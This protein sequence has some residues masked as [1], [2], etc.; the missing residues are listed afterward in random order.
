[1]KDLI[2]LLLAAALV[3]FLAISNPTTEEFAQWYAV[4]CS[5]GGDTPL[6]SI[7][8]GFT[9]YLAQRAVRDNYLVCSVYTYDGHATLGIALQFIPVDGLSEQVADLRADYAQWLKENTEKPVQTP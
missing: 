7:K 1:M 4:Q 3:A 6:D 5:E 2:S 9:E 8:D